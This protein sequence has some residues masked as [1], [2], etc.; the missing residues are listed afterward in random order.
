MAWA[1]EH[2]P[3]SRQAD[4]HP[5]TNK[6]LYLRSLQIGGYPLA[7]DDLSLEEWM[8]LGRLKQTLEPSPTCPMMKRSE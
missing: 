4:L 6:L 3:K 7:A 8:D 1:C 2:C 5:Y